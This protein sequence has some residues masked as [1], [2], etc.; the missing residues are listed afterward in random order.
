M[1]ICTHCHQKKPL[2]APVC[3]HCNH[4]ASL[5]ERVV[6][7]LVHVVLTFV[8]FYYLIYGVLVG[9]PWLVDRLIVPHIGQ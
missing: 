9:F 6:F 1:A 2:F 5:T 8:L 7:N 4:E 3:H